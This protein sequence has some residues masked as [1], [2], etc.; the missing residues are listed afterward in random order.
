VSFFYIVFWVGLVLLQTFFFHDYNTVLKKNT[1]SAKKPVSK[2]LTAKRTIDVKFP[3]YLNKGKKSHLPQVTKRLI[4][5]SSSSLFNASRKK[6]LQRGR[7]SFSRS[8]TGP[9]G[10]FP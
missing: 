6:P 8:K 5:D 2:H 7:P 10:R 3:E 9:V 1:F 4:R